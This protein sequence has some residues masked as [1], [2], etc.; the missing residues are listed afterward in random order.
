VCALPQV[1][2]G[3]RNLQASFAAGSVTCKITDFGMAMRF[4][5]NRSHASGVRQAR[6][7]DAVYVCTASLRA[8][9]CREHRRAPSCSQHGLAKSV[10]AP[11]QGTPFFMA[12]EVSRE[13]R[14]HKASDVYAYGVIMWELMMGCPVYIDMCACGHSFPCLPTSVGTRASP[15]SCMHRLSQARVLNGVAAA[16]TV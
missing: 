7:P 16:A 11:V 10:A 2:S 3:K 13:H 1:A 6:L 4:N 5:A 14:L 9:P 12:P 8:Q 15:S